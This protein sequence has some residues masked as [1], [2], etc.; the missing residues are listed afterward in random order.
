MGVLC[1]HIDGRDRRWPQVSQSMHAAIIERSGVTPAY[2]EIAEP[3]ASGNFVR[4]RVAASALSHVT[5]SRAGG[6]H[7][8]AAASRHFVPGIDGTGVLEDGRRVYFVMPEAPH[9]GMAEWSIVDLRRCIA[10]PDNVS[11]VVAAA[12]AIPGMSSWVALKERAKFS[13]GG[14][15]LVNGAT[16]VSGCL[17]VQ[18]AR[19]LGAKKVI[20]TGRNAQALARLSALGADVTI[21]LAQ[22]PDALERAL[23]AQFEGGIGVVLDYLWGASAE[24][25]L[26]AA[27]RAAP[28]AVPIRY[29]QIGAAGG[30]DITLPGAVL[31]SSAIELLG[32]GINSV[33]L[34]RMKSA[35]GELFESASR[36][37]FEAPVQAVA[38]ARVAEFWDRPEATPRIVFTI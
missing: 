4:V 16:G 7:Y 9:G 32:S 11:D 12:I 5:K 2:G 26:A 37:A 17:A 27:A 13:A 31:R 24:T 20:A 19:R 38:L 30:P 6:Q 36:A 28:E 3:R 29:V 33:P 14:T 1:T 22:E 34:A 25:I 15:V 35:I 10:L 18:V 8:S 21:S 23:M